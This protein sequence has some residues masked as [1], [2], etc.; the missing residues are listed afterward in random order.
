MAFR[1]RV[2]TAKLLQF[3]RAV[4]ALLNDFR[5]VWKEQAPIVRQEMID[6]FKSQNFGTWPPITK[7]TRRW[8]RRRGYDPGAPPLQAS[9]KLMRSIEGGD[10]SIDLQQQKSMTLGTRLPQAA[11]NQ[12]GAN[13][14]VRRKSDKQKKSGRGRKSKTILRRVSVPARPF[15][16]DGNSIKEP[17]AVKL[18]NQMQLFMNR[19]LVQK[20]SESP[21]KPKE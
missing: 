12:V 5:P 14:K 13:V 6:Q 4:V 11:P 19:Y 1:V 15:I 10:G 21:T 17:F 18:S 2:L 3:K 16:P 8:R 9:R 7:A 20:L